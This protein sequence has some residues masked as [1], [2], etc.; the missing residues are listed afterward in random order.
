MLMV[1]LQ[2]AKKNTRTDSL[3]RWRI[4]DTSLVRPFMHAE[5][6]FS[7]LALHCTVFILAAPFSF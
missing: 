3:G 2:Y 1:N 7:S 6:D 4:T 5:K